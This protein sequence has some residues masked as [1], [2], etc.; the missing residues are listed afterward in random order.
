MEEFLHQAEMVYDVVV[1][2]SP[3]LL[4][5]ADSRVLASHVEAVML[6]V[7]SGLTPRKLVKQACANLRNVPGRVI[8]VVLNQVDTSGEDYSYPRSDESEE[9]E[10][11]ENSHE[12]LRD[13]RATA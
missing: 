4:N 9:S 7:H 11:S 1:L 3:I 10:Y 6:V 5:M 13:R 2:D 12:T 8:G